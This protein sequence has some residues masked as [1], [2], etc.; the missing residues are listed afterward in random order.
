M[1]TTREELI[2]TGIEFGPAVD[3][4]YMTLTL[5]ILVQVAVSK[6]YRCHIDQFVFVCYM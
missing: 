1:W 4:G 5:E 6:G 2:C 3:L